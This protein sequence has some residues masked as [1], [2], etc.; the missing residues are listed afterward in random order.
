MAP[1]L[2]KQQEAKGSLENFFEEFSSMKSPQVKLNNATEG[3][4]IHVISED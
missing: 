2:R 1:S 4:P 3:E